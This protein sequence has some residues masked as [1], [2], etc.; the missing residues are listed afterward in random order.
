[1]VVQRMME[2]RRASM[3]AIGMITVRMVV[4]RRAMRPIPGSPP[5][6]IEVLTSRDLR[7]HIGEVVARKIASKWALPRPS[8]VPVL[9]QPNN[10]RSIAA[11]FSM[12]YKWRPPS[13]A[14]SS[15]TWI[16]RSRDCS[17]RMSA[18]RQRMFTS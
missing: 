3:G 4:S 13:K 6:G 5:G 11:I 7:R 10:F 17:C 2:D 12:Q 15:Q 14:V 1:M 18:A 9:F 8:Q 16:S